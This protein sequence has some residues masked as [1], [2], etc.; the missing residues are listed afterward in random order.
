MAL[1][2]HDGPPHPRPPIREMRICLQF[3]KLFM[4]GFT[5]STSIKSKGMACGLLKVCGSIVDPVLKSF[6]FPD[7]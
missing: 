7:F 3:S 1:P 2:G 5:L 4:G 6:G